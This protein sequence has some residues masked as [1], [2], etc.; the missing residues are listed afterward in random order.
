ML[1]ITAYALGIASLACDFLNPYV[2]VFGVFFKAFLLF[3]A[4]VALINANLRVRELA[5][6]APPN[7]YNAL[8]ARGIM[9]EQTSR[10]L[11]SGTAKGVVALIRVAAVLIIA[12]STL[13][14]G[15]LSFMVVTYPTDLSL[16][17]IISLGKGAG[18]ALF[19]VSLATAVASAALLWKKATSI[20]RR[21]ASPRR[22]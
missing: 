13:L 1:T 11:S 12:C 2:G 10:S 20:K 4:G 15:L 8:E 5:K 7:L 16:A 14:N 6:S 17:P 19:A 21:L 3:F 9:N 22:R 18:P